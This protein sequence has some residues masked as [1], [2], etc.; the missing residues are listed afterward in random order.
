MYFVYSFILL[1]VWMIACIVRSDFS[2][3]N[4]L[5]KCIGIVYSRNQVYP[6]GCSTYSDLMDMNQVCNGPLWFLTS[7]ATSMGA[8]AILNRLTQRH[9]R[10]IVICAFLGLHILCSCLPVLL[11]WSMDAAFAGALFMLAGKEL[12]EKAII[13]SK[14]MSALTIFIVLLI[15]VI[16]GELNGVTNMSIRLWG[17]WGIASAFAFIL[18]G[19]CGTILLLTFCYKIAGLRLNKALSLIGKNTLNILAFHLLVFK[20]FPTANIDNGM[21]EFYFY[22]ICVVLTTT[23][24]IVGASLVLKKCVNQKSIGRIKSKD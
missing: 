13:G 3:M 15:F 16:V 6:D 20:I 17:K 21:T 7:Y 22:N 18:T 24:I 8:Y 9:N 19:I 4:F 14:R 23:F 10:N 11:P 12:K 2:I 1:A 5:Y